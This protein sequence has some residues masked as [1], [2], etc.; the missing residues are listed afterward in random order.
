MSLRCRLLV[1]E[2]TLQDPNFHRTVVYLIEHSESGALGLVLNR[3]GDVPVREAVPAWAPYVD[4]GGLVFVGGPVS[5][6]GAI[7]LARC[8]SDGPRESLF[9]P[10]AGVDDGDETEPDPTAIFKPITTTIGALDL[11]GDPSDAP[12]GIRALRIFAGYAGWSGGQLELELESGGWYVVD[13]EDDD[14]FTEHPELLWRE[15][16]RR[17]P[18]ALRAIAFHPGDPTWN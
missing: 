1:A 15:V 8:P 13:A 6:E 4:G 14:V 12:A 17:Q 5:P 10:P 3:P 9:E 11:H 2:P 7:C 16:L 18:G